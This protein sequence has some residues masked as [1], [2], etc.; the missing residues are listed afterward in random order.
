MNRNRKVEE[1]GI[2]KEEKEQTRKEQ[3]QKGGKVQT[4]F[5][6]W[7]SIKIITSETGMDRIEHATYF[8]T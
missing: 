2:K 4:F 7:I 8:F 1:E 5:L 6:G 3:E